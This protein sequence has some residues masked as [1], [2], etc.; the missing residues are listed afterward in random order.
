MYSF[1]KISMPFHYSWII[2]VAVILI[3]NLFN[4]PLAREDVEKRALFA[5]I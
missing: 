3:F 1:R 4:M 5:S 2:L